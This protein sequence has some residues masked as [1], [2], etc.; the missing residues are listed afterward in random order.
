MLTVKIRFASIRN[1]SNGKLSL[2][3]S[4]ITDVQYSI[5]CLFD[6]AMY[7][8]TQIDFIFH[9][10]Y[11]TFSSE[12]KIYFFL[13]QVPRKIASFHFAILRYD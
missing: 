2:A 12:H 10:I 11:F 13:A 1:K 3:L 7:Y 8:F 9:E 5:R 4:K 6:F